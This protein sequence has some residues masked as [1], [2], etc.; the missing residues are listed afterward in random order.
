MGDGSQRGDAALVRELADA[1]EIEGLMIHYFDA[2]D[3]LDPFRAVEIFTD[4]IE[5]DFMTGKVYRGPRTIARALGRILLQYQQTSHHITNHRAQIDGDRATALTYI[6]AFHRMRD[7]DDTWH[8]WA[9]HVDQLVRVDGRWKVSHRVLA[10][11]DSVP[12]W[13]KIDDSWYYGHPGRRPHAD[14]E[15][16]LR[17][18]AG[19]R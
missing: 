14:L 9:R 1:R 19:E 11:I 12:R 10:A 15:E 13:E 3:A 7:S 17:A 6:Y 18:T 2:V 16:Q 8:L 4:D 5:G